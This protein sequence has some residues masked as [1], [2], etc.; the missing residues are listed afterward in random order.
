MACHNLHIAPPTALTK[1]AMY[2]RVFTIFLS[3]IAYTRPSYQ[4][5]ADEF[6]EIEVQDILDRTPYPRPLGVG[7][8]AGQG[9]RQI[10]S[11]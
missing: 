10:V 5:S 4:P 1:V 9:A 7:Q 8:R 3:H 6:I 2:S 11:Q